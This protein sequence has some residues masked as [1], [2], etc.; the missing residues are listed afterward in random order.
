[1]VLTCGSGSSV[2]V[3]YGSWVAADGTQS[4]AYC[5]IPTTITLVDVQYVP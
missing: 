3:N 5:R 1:M 4:H 2:N